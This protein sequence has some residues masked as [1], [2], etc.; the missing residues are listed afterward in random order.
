MLTRFKMYITLTH[1]SKILD[2]NGGK[3][4]GR[5]IEPLANTIEKRK[6]LKALE[7]CGCIN[8]I[9]ADHSDIPLCIQE[10]DYSVIYLLSRR[11]LWFNRILC[12][13]S[14]ILSGVLIAWFTSML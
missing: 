10:G 5:N 6:I 7:Q 13:A 4:K 3:I 14:G 8:C 12:Y 1:I 2:K 9:Y 11:E